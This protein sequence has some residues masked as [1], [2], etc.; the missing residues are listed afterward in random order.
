MLFWIVTFSSN[1]TKLIW[2]EWLPLMVTIPPFVVHI[3]NDGKCMRSPL[4]LNISAISHLWE[5]IRFERKVLNCLQRIIPK[6]QCHCVLKLYDQ[7][8]FKKSFK[9]YISVSFIC[10][11]LV[12][13]YVHICT[14]QIHV[15]LYLR[16]CTVSIYTCIIT[17]VQ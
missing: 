16:V 4:L 6:N 1:K 2:W 9:L 14:V 13:A 17:L 8:S 11:R 12:F 3:S 5:G 7:T 15:Y 10:C